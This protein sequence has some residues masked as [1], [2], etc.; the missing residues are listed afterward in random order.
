MAN[1]ARL[2]L[3]ARRNE[4]ARFTIVVKGIDLTGVNMA[5]QVR[6]S[7]DNPMLLFALA[8]VATVSAEGLKLD[9]VTMTNGVPTSIIKGRI[10]AS[11]M[12]DATK[13]PYAGEAGDNSNFAYA[14]QW[15]LNGDA[16]TRLYGDFIAVASAF[17]SDSAPANRPVGYGGSQQASVDDTGSLTF[18]DQIINV[19]LDDADILIPFA[20]SAAA[21]AATAQTAAAQAQAARDSLSAIALGGTGKGLLYK[22][23]GT[24]TGWTGDTAAWTSVTKPALVSFNPSSVIP[25]APG[26]PGASDY[27]G[28]REGNWYE[29]TDGT[30]YMLSDSGNGSTT[31]PGGPW[32]IQYEK[33]TDRGLTWTKM[34]AFGGIGLK[35]GYDSGN[36]ASRGNLGV[37]KHTNGKYYCYTLTALTISNNQVAGQPYT[38]DVWSAD[39]FEGPYT[40][41]ASQL[42]SGPA[43][44][45]DALDAY[46]G[47]PPIKDANGLW[48]L[49]YSAT[50]K[51]AT[52]WY[53]GRA[54]GPSPT[55]PWTRTGSPVLPDGVRRQD[56]NPKVFFHTV[57]NKWV[58]MTNVINPAIGTTDSNAAYFSNSLT[59]WSAATSVVTQRI[60]PMDGTTAIGM[61]SP[62]T[63]VLGSVVDMDGLGNV[64]IVFDTDPRPSGSNH[65]GRRLKYAILEPTTKELAGKTTSGNGTILHPLAHSSF[66]ADFVVRPNTLTG[67]I[68]FFYRMQAPGDI[69]N[70]YMLTF[71]VGRVSDLAFTASL[72][73]IVNGVTTQLNVSGANA[74][75]RSVAGLYHRVTI[76]IQGQRHVVRVDGEKQ[77]D[78]ADTT[79]GAGLGM[80]FR[81]NGGADVGI[82]IF[83]V[84]ES[85]AAVINGVAPGQV[86]SLRG[87]GYIPLAYGVVTGTQISL[88]T[89]HY[90]VSAVSVDGVNIY[91]PAAGVWGGEVIG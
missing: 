20:Q 85:N 2:D 74:A 25:W 8:T 6:L 39:T 1:A 31:D 26:A 16:Q 71:D 15:T 53:I 58:M 89:T 70:C 30:Y 24:L 3:A 7:K 57:L 42:V 69:L 46:I 66:V 45:F 91:A 82:P 41:V 75:V 67:T 14:M 73:K 21:S 33:S 68:N 56:E 48:H 60:S 37:L 63:K 55:G 13:V 32:I 35:H 87:V 18:G 79:F 62:K 54:T 78:F 19:T 11:T 88:T 34:G 86:A 4:V 5:M 80:G 61:A 49:F 43:G 40:F 65:V 28:V 64:P 50:D 52:N 81:L 83:T 10:N 47:G 29:D 36:W 84:R 90:P 72:S 76:E 59:D 38:S 23:D 77:I 22:S 44:S 9:S 17:G 12:S 51:A 27:G